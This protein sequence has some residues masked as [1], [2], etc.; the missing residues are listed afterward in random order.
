MCAPVVGPHR[1]RR[2]MLCVPRPE[3]TQR[4]SRVLRR[5]GLKLPGACGPS[6]CVVF[7]AP[8]EV[9]HDSHRLIEPSRWN[10]PAPEAVRM[11]LE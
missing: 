5:T 11:D 6:Q 1:Y 7:R 8:R 4:L 3:K 2:R 10:Y 9:W